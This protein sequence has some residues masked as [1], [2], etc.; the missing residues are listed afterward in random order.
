MF[1][2]SRY[3]GALD[4][5]ESVIDNIEVSDNN[6]PSRIICELETSEGLEILKNLFEIENLSCD[7]FKSNDLILDILKVNKQ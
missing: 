2:G 1:L 3:F 6:V 5:T 7:W 4:S